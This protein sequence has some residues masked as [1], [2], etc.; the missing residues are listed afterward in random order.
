[1]LDKENTGLIVVDI[2]GTLARLVHDSDTLILHC[3]K[4]IKGAQTLNLPIIWLEQNPDKLGSTIQELDLLHDNH[5]PITKFTFNA[6][7]SPEFVEAIRAANKESWLICGI[8]AHVCVYQTALNL[9]ELGLNV[10]LVSD[11]VSSRTVTNKNLAIS[12]LA[13]QGVN[14]TG[15]EMCLFELVKDCRALEFKDILELIK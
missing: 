15:L 3:K 4:L 14:I 7:L 2:Q 1:M 13:N 12:K 11:C 9:K 10:Q 5:T 6:C 8:E